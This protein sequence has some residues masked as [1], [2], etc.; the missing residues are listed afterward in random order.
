MRE[1]VAEDVSLEWEQKADLKSNLGACVREVPLDQGLY[2]TT[3]CSPVLG[4]AC[5]EVLAVYL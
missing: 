1:A 5:H 2:G 4:L 3:L